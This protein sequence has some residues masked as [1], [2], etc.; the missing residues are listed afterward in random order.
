LPSFAPVRV[1]AMAA[2]A[3]NS[4]Y[5][6]TF[7]ERPALCRE[8]T[9]CERCSNNTFWQALLAC[10]FRLPASAQEANLEPLK[11]FFLVGSG[12]KRQ[13]IITASVSVPDADACRSACREN[14]RRP[15]LRAVPAWAFFAGLWRRRCAQP[16]CACAGPRRS[17]AGVARRRIEVIRPGVNGEDDFGL[18]T[19]IGATRIEVLRG[20]GLNAIYGSDAIGLVSCPCRPKPGRRSS[21]SNSVNRHAGYRPAPV[22]PFAGQG[23][24]PALWR[25]VFQAFSNGRSSMWPAC[26]GKRVGSDAFSGVAPG[27]RWDLKYGLEPCPVLAIL[28]AARRPASTPTRDYGW[29]ARTNTDQNRRRPATLIVASLPPV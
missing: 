1:Q 18:L 5:R 27:P 15:V 7:G 11:P 19:G 17:H 8:Q 25:T 23:W 4:V 6:D 26:D 2:E 14:V 9:R 3:N 22:L 10:R 28:P 21:C 16:G 13:T 24:R 20:R 29:P 12:P